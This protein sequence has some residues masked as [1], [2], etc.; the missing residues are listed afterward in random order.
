[1]F[2]SELEIE[3]SDRHPATT[4]M[5][6]ANLVTAVDRSI[7]RVGRKF[8]ALLLAQSGQIAWLEANQYA[9]RLALALAV[10]PVTYGAI[11][12]VIPLA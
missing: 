5:V 3:S 2:G 4:Q 9:N 11:V 12:L 10:R 6:G 7:D 8:A 1:M